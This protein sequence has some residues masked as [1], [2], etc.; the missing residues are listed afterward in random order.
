[1]PYCG[2]G[3]KDLF[4]SF[5]QGESGASD[6]TLAEYHYSGSTWALVRTKNMMYAHAYVLHE[7]VLRPYSKRLPQGWATDAA[8]TKLAKQSM[9]AGAS[10]RRDEEEFSLIDQYSIRRKGAPRIGN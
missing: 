9:Y 4:G 3:G 8:L 7:S 1:M 2:L 5:K 10:I 6:H